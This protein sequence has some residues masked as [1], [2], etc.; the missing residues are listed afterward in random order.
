MGNSF[1][2]CLPIKA[3]SESFFNQ[4]KRVLYFNH[5]FRHQGSMKLFSPFN[6][7]ANKILM[8]LLIFID[9]FINKTVKIIIARKIYKFTSNII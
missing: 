3:P 8:I 1:F 9:A 6:C 5:T 4:T 2:A 7:I